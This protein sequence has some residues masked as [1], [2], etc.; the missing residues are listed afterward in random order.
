MTEQDIADRVLDALRSARRLRLPGPGLSAERCVEDID[1][2]KMRLSLLYRELRGTEPPRGPLRQRP[3]A[4]AF[5]EGRV[6]GTRA[7][8]Q[9]RRRVRRPAAASE[10]SQVFSGSG[11]A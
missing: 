4:L 7:I 2:L 5:P 11:A 10:K 3:T 8:V 1:D 9:H 6:A